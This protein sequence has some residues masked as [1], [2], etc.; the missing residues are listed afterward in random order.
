MSKYLVTASALTIREG[1]N[2]TF[3]AIGYLKE[4]DIVD[5]LESNEDDSWKKVQTLSGLIGWCS[6]QYLSPVSSSPPIDIPPSSGSYSVKPI[7][8]FIRQGPQRNYRVVGF[9]RMGDIV[10]SIERSL[11]DAWIRI[12]NKKGI[13]GWCHSKYLVPENNSVSTETGMHWLAKY[14][15]NI[16]RNPGEDLALIGQASAD[17]LVNVFEL[18]NDKVW[19]KIATNLGLT[20]WCLAEYL[21]S[22][23]NIGKQLQNEE[24]PWMP[25]AFGEIGV[26]EYP[27]S[28]HNARIQEY[29]NSTVLGD[30]PTLPDETHWCAAF[31]NWCVEKAGIAS[32]NSPVVSSWT[33][34]GQTLG[35]PRRGCIVTFKW[36]DGGSH[37]AFFL[38]ESGDKV[39]ALGGNQSDGVWIMSYPKKNVTTYR[40]P[41]NW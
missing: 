39:Y 3:K 38:G 24:F 2:K 26:R 21:I 13:T 11:D 41:A 18:S 32:N 20:G 35:V 30:G 34:W 17:Y 28:R 15:V 7:A 22:L 29:L 9:V 1:P 6:S 33:R 27:G 36:D 31:V 4:M 14:N 23:G 12:R 8:S 10:E 16:Y 40:I 37:V 19:K 5:V 25:I